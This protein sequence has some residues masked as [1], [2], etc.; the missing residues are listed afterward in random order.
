MDCCGD[1]ANGASAQA[2]RAS[3]HGAAANGSAKP[4]SNGSA[5]P[6]ANRS[7][8]PV[9]KSSTYESVQSYYGEVCCF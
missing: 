9:A 8:E 7:A 2:I 3:V 5:K 1:G 6:V 4:M